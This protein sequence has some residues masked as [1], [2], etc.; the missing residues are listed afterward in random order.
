MVI[1][2]CV[3]LCVE[4]GWQEEGKE[5]QEEE[6]VTSICAHDDVLFELQEHVPVFILSVRVCLEHFLS[7]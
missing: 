1:V 4:K 6:K 2:I 3:Y 7:P 5:D